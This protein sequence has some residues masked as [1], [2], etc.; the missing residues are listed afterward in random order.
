MEEM[1]IAELGKFR[2]PNSTIFGASQS[3]HSEFRNGEGIADCGLRNAELGM[4]EMRIAELGKFRIPNST[5]F[6][7]SQSSHSEFRNPLFPFPISLFH[8]CIDKSVGRS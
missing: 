1:R 2:I 3:S 4:E 8:D 5:I 7:A 6:G